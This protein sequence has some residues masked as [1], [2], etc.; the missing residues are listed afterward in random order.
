MDIPV[1][2]TD[3]N[4]MERHFFLA[5]Q[6]GEDEFFSNNN[7]N[8]EWDVASESWT[9]RQNMEHT[10]GHASSSTTPVD[11]GFIIAGGSSNNFGKIRYEAIPCMIAS[12][13]E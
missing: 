8:Y 4:G 10:R 6:R 11:C 5:G 7:E 13:K 3:E 1:T 9:R 12:S 2:T